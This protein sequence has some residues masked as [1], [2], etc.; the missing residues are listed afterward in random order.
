ML[1]RDVQQHQLI[2]Y[3]EF[4]DLIENYLH[5]TK[6]FQ[7]SIKAGLE[8]RCLTKE[9][10][11]YLLDIKAANLDLTQLPTVTVQ[12]TSGET[13]KLCKEDDFNDYLFMKK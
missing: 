8:Y 7:D 10:F 4:F 12:A 5:K 13:L 2:F 6:I 1:V 3:K 11:K 9:S